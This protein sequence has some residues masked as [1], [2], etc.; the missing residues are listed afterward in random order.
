[1]EPIILL[2]LDLLFREIRLPREI[3]GKIFFLLSVVLVGLINKCTSFILSNS[4]K[5]ALSDEGK[6]ERE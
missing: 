2:K 5:N 3:G 1:V 6:A 4:I